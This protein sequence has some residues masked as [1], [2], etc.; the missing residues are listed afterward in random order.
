MGDREHA[1]LRVVPAIADIDAG[2]W[3]ACANPDA[4]PFDPFVAHRFLVAL[5]R[6]GWSGPAPAGCP[7][8]SCC[9]A[10]QAKSPPPR[11]AM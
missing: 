10:R 8:T 9:P 2:A 5:D 3:D 11:R 4:E 7:A 6:R 1:V